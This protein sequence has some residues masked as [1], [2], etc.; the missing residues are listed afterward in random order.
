M[1]ML[2]CPFKGT[3]GR[4]ERTERVTDEVYQMIELIIIERY[5]MTSFIFFPSSKTRSTSGLTETVVM[6]S[7]DINNKIALRIRA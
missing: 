7:L 4:T 5:F 3:K 6:R 2:S 1:P